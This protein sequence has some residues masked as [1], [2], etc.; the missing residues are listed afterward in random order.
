MQTGAYYYDVV[1]WAVKNGITF[2]ITDTIFGPNVACTRTQI[3]SFLW[4]QASS[5][6]MSG[7]NPFMDVSA[8]DYYY[9]AVLWSA[10][11]GI[12]RHHRHHVQPQ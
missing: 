11:N 4:R 7:D 5:P 3:L 1:A 8:A 12:A 2:G 10:V 9:D 6:K